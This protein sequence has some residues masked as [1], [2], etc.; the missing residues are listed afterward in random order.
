MSVIAIRARRDAD[1]SAIVREQSPS[2]LS[3]SGGSGTMLAAH[4]RLDSSQS[5]PEL[6][7]RACDAA[8]AA[9]GFD[10]ALVVCVD[11]QVLTTDGIGALTDDATDVMR[12]RL[13][14]QPVRMRPGTMEAEIIW[15]A[16]AGR[17]ET[18]QA[19]SVLDAVL[20]LEDFV[21]APVMPEDRVLALLVLD[22]SGPA[23]GPADRDVADM[24]AHLL[25][26]SVARLVMRQRMSE[27]AAELR[28]LTTSAQALI[29][30][31][32]E[33]AMALP[34]DHGAGPVF[35]CEYPPP[36]STD[37]A[38]ELFTRRELNIAAQMVHGRSNREI[39][40]ELQISPET[41]KTYVARVM[42]KLGA[43]N[44]ADAAVRY[45][46]MTSSSHSA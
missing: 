2:T 41:V 5:I 38:R 33:S 42:R 36:P 9:C 1:E 31:G 27:F 15:A 44:R 46:R 16:E 30:E 40:A 29:K 35:A 26:C 14:A 28:H 34:K 4:R 18:R 37:E 3:A 7:T 10:R 20:G 8:R 11:D 6:L 45:L 39:A 23:V 17:G 22:R 21:M 32:L 43:S 12:R 13:L 25:G 24:F 19:S